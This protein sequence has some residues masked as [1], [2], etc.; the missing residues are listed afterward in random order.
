L[1]VPLS[2]AILLT[3]PGI[4]LWAILLRRSYAKS[5]VAEP[6]LINAVESVH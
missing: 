6:S 3:L 2:I 4:L 1:G 5:G